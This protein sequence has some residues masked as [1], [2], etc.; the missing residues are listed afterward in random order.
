MRDRIAR[1]LCWVLALL[2]SRTRRPGRHSAAYLAEH[3]A[4]APFVICAPATLIPA[5]VLARS[6]PSPW[7]PR[8]G[9]WLA[10]R[11]AEQTLE[12]CAI[13]ERRRALE[14]ATRG[15]D[16]PYSYPGAPFAASAF[17]AAGVTA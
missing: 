10:A 15:R 13:R 14:F 8:V 5:H 1:A 9:P 7:A 11:E 6:I 16:Y 4:T 3:A 2:A 12:L 17:A